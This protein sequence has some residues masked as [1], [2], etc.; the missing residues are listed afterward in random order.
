MDG[1]MEVFA[2]REVLRSSITFCISCCWFVKV[3][4]DS[5]LSRWVCGLRRP[6]VRGQMGA[7][8]GN[9]MAK[10]H[11]TPGQSLKFPSEQAL[12]LHAS[13]LRGVH[14]VDA[15]CRGQWS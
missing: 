3:G 9:S 10:K 4:Q 8:E 7:F 13:F 5:N 14:G 11:W 15:G 12:E 6:M 2:Q 1:K